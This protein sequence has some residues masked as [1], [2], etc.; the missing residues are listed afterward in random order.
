V[1]NGEVY[2]HRKTNADLSAR[3]HRFHSDC[4]TETLAHLYAEYGTTFPAKTNG[5][6]AALA[7][8]SQKD[9]FIAA[10][11]PFGIKPLYYVTDKRGRTI[12]C[13][14]IRPLQN[15]AAT[16]GDVR[17]IEP[18]TLWVNGKSEKYFCPQIGMPPSYKVLRDAFIDAV[19][20]HLPPDSAMPTGIFLSGGLDSG[21]VAYIA[22]Q[23]RNN[24][25]ALIA[26][27]ED[28]G[29]DAEPARL[30]AERLGIEYEIVTMRPVEML[31]ALPD[32]IRH[33]ENYDYFQ[34]LCALP[35]WF[36]SKR[37]KELGMK[38]VLS[39]DGSD[40]LFGGYK[41]YLDWVERCAPYLHSK[42]LTEVQNKWAIME[43][44]SRTAL[45]EYLC[46]SELQRG[47]RMTAAFGLE[48]RVP[49]LDTTFANLAMSLPIQEKVPF[50]SPSDDRIK[51]FL[52]EAFRGSVPD[53][54][55]DSPKSPLPLSSGA[56]ENTGSS[57]FLALAEQR[58]LN[59]RPK[60]GIQT[61]MNMQ[62]KVEEYFFALWKQS[63]GP[64]AQHLEQT[65][66]S[67]K[68]INPSLFFR[69]PYIDPLAA[70][71]F[72]PLATKEGVAMPSF[73]HDFSPLLPPEQIPCGWSSA[74]RPT[75]P[76]RP[77]ASFHPIAAP[78]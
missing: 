30:L 18:G 41:Y 11:D 62:Y 70:D 32:V 4:D 49:F 2:N 47:D 10:R 64:F 22:S 71:G 35:F 23:K 8:D 37:A 69:G 50:A 46:S 77:D 67:G 26:K 34:V 14:E 1:L 75:T 74:S 36:L 15:L 59:L 29:S 42:G 16:P 12:F 57:S 52:R 40:E 43:M 55:V 54:V 27:T 24:I 73:A 5:M 39:G 56:G 31:N 48:L 44:G 60:A 25:V 6:F 28:G 51:L 3:G 68:R 45:S 19:D 66:Q 13:S 17:V 38:V 20:S 78:R 58:W 72:G 53:C 65:A 76:S 7:Y 33:L 63:L 61:T 21:L 9:E